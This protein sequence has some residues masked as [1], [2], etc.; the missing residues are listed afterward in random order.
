[1]TKVPAKVWF[2][3]CPLG[4]QIYPVVIS[5]DPESVTGADLLVS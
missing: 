3:V 4:L 1:M 2:T 5:P